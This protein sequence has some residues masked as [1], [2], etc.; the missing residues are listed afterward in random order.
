[1]TTVLDRPVVTQ[2]SAVELDGVGKAF[3]RGPD[4][5]TALSGVDLRVRAL[6][7]AARR[8]CSTWS[9]GWTS[10]APA[11]SPCTAADPR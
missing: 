9:P 5:V 11:R 6:P 3:G 1:M 8:R 2:R 10:P 7:A 4:A